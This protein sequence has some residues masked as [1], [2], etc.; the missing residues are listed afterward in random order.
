MFT[1]NNDKAI[2]NPDYAQHIKSLTKLKNCQSCQPKFA[3]TAIYQ[4]VY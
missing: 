1:K 2:V 3:V 4:S